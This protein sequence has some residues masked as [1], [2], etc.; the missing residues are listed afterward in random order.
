MS[1]DSVTFSLK[2]HHGCKPIQVTA[3]V[4]PKIDGADN[5]IY[6]G[7]DTMSAN[8]V[9]IDTSRKRMKSDELWMDCPM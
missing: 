5:C 3:W 7:L 2:G 6:V 8:G 9:F 4:I 1:N